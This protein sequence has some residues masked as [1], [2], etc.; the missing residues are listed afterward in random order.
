LLGT[1]GPSGEATDVRVFF[2]PFAAQTNDT[3]YDINSPYPSTADAWEA[4]VAARGQQQRRHPMFATGNL[5]SQTDYAAGGP[6]KHNIE[7][8]TG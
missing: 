1:A 7:I 2:R 3:D 5:P 8:A 6:N 4:W